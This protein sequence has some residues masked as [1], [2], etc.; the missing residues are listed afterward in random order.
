MSLL[1]WLLVFEE[2]EVLFGVLERCVF[3]SVCCILLAGATRFPT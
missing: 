3:H 2:L 1:M